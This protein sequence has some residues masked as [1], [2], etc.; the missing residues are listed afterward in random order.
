MSLKSIEISV[1]KGKL[2]LNPPTLQVALDDY[3]QWCVKP[4]NGINAATVDATSCPFG[5][6]GMINIGWNVSFSPCFPCPAPAIT[7]KGKF[8]YSVCACVGTAPNSVSLVESG[9]LVVG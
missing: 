7:L 5:G 8:Q 4:N 6:G 2:K 9:E 3:V 1:D